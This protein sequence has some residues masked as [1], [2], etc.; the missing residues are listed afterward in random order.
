MNGETEEINDGIVS[1]LTGE[2][3]SGADVE[4]F[5]CLDKREKEN[6]AV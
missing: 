2:C 6:K 4:G 3:V 1:G 5:R